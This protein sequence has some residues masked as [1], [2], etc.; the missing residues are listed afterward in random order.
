[1][2]ASAG[3]RGRT[4]DRRRRQRELRRE[5]TTWQAGARWA[6]ELV[7]EESTA[8]QSPQ[9]IPRMKISIVASLCALLLAPGTAEAQAGTRTSVNLRADSTRQRRPIRVLARQE[10]LEIVSP[11]TTRTGFIAVRTSRGEQGWVAADYV[12]LADPDT[13]DAVPVAPIGASAVLAGSSA[14]ATRDNPTDAIRNLDNPLTSI[15]PDLEKPALHGSTINYRGDANPR[16][17]SCG[18]SG[19]GK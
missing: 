12:W 16:H 3:E 6:Y 4:R 2:D 14:P 11:D 13:R 5:G 10:R 8:A 19:A 17:R 18:P 1:M 7:R 15:T 9:L